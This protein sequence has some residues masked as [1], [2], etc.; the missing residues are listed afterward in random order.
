[1]REVYDFTVD[2]YHNYCAGDLVHHNTFSGGGYEAALHLTGLYPD[3][4]KGKVFDKPVRALCAGDTGQTTRDI[5]QY[6]LF[7]TKDHKNTYELGTR[8]IPLDCIDI[9][10]IMGKM[11]ISGGIDTV[12]I[13][14]VSGGYSECALK[15]YDQ[16]R[17]IFQ[18]EAK[19]LVWFDE[20]P[21]ADVY[22]E[23][24]IRTMTTGGITMLTF[25]PL[26]GMSEVVMSFLP[27]EYQLGA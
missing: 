1:M 15:S 6:E 12:R 17:R 11:G 8:L 21:P 14:H 2:V 23:A 20:E 24:L 16:G 25:T 10:S 9:D 22:N 27:K 26:Q 7:G 4:W 3:W 5:I 13:K 19:E 18:G